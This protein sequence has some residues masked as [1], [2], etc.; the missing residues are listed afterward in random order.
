MAKKTDVFELSGTK[1]Y[2]K[3]GNLTAGV[4]ENEIR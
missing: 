2:D 4:N 3:S 1:S